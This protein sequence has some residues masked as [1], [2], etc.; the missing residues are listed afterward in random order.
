MR[1]QNEQMKLDRND[2]II[3]HAKELEEERNQRRTL[4]TEN[5]KMKFRVKC[6]EDDLQK[7]VL[8]TEKKI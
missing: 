4:N 8:K 7:S 5:E 1:K 6:L 2:Q 3:R